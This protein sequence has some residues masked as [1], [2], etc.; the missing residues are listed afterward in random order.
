MWLTDGQLDGLVPHQVGAAAA[1][2]DVALVTR[3]EAAQPWVDQVDPLVRRQVGD[4]QAFVSGDYLLSRQ[5]ARAEETTRTLYQGPATT[6]GVA[7]WVYFSG[8]RVWWRLSWR[9]GDQIE[10]VLA[11]APA[12]ALDRLAE[13]MSALES[14]STFEVDPMLVIGGACDTTRTVDRRA[15]VEASVRRADARAQ[16]VA[17]QLAIDGIVTRAAETCLAQVLPT[18]G[19][20]RVLEGVPVT[21]ADRDLQGQ[22]LRCVDGR[23]RLPLRIQDRLDEVG[24]W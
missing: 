17:E 10:Q 19:A 18:T 9:T 20:C 22:V 13:D 5:H 8:D 3:A 6:P 11:W 12:D 21:E 4:V 14:D 7:R 1:T 15:V 23:A 2:A 16:T 24:A